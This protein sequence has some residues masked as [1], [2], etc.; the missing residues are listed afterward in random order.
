M[1]TYPFRDGKK[2]TPPELRRDCY[3]TALAEQALAFRDEKLKRE[4]E[5]KQVYKPAM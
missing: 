1:R 2:V 3:K 4:E 5:R